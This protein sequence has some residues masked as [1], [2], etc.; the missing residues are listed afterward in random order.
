MDY[1]GS[2]NCSKHGPICQPLSITTSQFLHSSSESATA[3]STAARPAAHHGHL[4]LLGARHDRPCQSIC[5]P[6]HK[7]HAALIHS[8]VLKCSTSPIRSPRI[9]PALEL[10]PGLGARSHFIPYQG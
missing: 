10:A 6:H 9:S 1:I 4:P 5:R 2:I 8:R 3:M 7:E